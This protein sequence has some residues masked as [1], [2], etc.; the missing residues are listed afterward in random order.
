[1]IWVNVYKVCKGRN[2]LWPIDLKRFLAPFILPGIKAKARNTPVGDKVRTPATHPEDF[3]RNGSGQYKNVNTGEVWESS[4]TNHSRS[5]GGEWK[6]GTKKGKAPTKSN[7]ITVAND[8]T[9]IKTDE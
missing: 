8:G 6:V 2:L 3:T 1:M 9:I 5:E 7:K 4:H